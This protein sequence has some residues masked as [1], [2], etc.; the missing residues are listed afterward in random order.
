MEL[1]KLEIKKMEQYLK[2]LQEKS[3][4][5][6]NKREAIMK[7]ERYLEAVHHSYQDEFDDVGSILNRYKQLID[8]NESLE[9]K[10]KD[11][12]DKSEKLKLTIDK[13]EKDKR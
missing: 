9:K 4:R 6:N 11:L 1:K 12:E 5:I 10:N 13:Y 2:T 8:T 3:K 7:Y